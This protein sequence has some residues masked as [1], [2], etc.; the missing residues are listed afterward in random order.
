MNA[1]LLR[2]C[3]KILPLALLARMQRIGDDRDLVCFGR[4][5]MQELEALAVEFRLHQGD[6]RRVEKRVSQILGDAR[7]Y[8]IGAEFIDDRH[9]PITLHHDRCRRGMCHDKLDTPPLELR[10]K[11]RNASSE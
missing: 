1:E 2:L 11:R 5:L 9:R 6:T 4:E 10:D 3:T 7:R 8:R